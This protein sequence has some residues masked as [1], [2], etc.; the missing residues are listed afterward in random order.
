MVA[1]LIFADQERLMHTDKKFQEIGAIIGRKW[2]QL[3]EK[4]KRVSISADT[5]NSQTTTSRSNH[6]NKPQHHRE[7]HF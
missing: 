1:Y 3:E 4:D 5:H 6:T 2:R 7:T